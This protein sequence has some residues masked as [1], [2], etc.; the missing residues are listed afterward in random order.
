MILY[1]FA[2]Q[3]IPGRQYLYVHRPTTLQVLNYVVLDLNTPERCGK[4]ISKKQNPLFFNDLSR[5][6]EDSLWEMCKSKDE[7]RLESRISDDDAVDAVRVM[8]QLFLSGIYRSS[9][10]VN[11]PLNQVFDER[12]QIFELS[13]GSDTR[14]R[15]IGIFPPQ[16]Q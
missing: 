6:L 11:A 12:F 15:R 1:S 13:L 7:T 8:H 4:G 9:M 3:S 5:F 2:D 14:K 10:P 16:N